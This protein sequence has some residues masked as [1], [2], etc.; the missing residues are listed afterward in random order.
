MFHLVYFAGAKIMEGQ[1]LLQMS[2][3]CNLS[4]GTNRYKF[5]GQMG[6]CDYRTS[7][8]SGF[9]TTFADTYMCHNSHALL[10]LDTGE[11]GMKHI[12]HA[13]SYNICCQES[14][15]THHAV[16][17]W[18]AV[19]PICDDGYVFTNGQ[20]CPSDHPLYCGNRNRCYS[21]CTDC[22]E[23]IVNEDADPVK[24]VTICESTDYVL[25]NGQCCPLSKPNYCSDR[26]KCRVQCS[27]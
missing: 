4:C 3:M 26:K 17:P 7:Y 23:C 1:Q 5:P 14:H 2:R 15:S 18:I 22:S 10:P 13:W 19:S 6:K 24:P 27:E 8:T 21:N 16:L 20:C 11:L 12:L 25:S 9:S